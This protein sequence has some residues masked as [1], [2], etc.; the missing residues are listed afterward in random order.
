[1]HKSIQIKGNTFSEHLFWDVD[2]TKLDI[3][4]NTSFIIKKILLYGFFDDWQT[5]FRLYGKESIIQQAKKIRELDIKTAHYIA[6][7][8]NTPITEFECYTTKLSSPPHWNF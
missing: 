4:L 1:M 8:T 5:M 2:Y 6:F 3:Q 7:I